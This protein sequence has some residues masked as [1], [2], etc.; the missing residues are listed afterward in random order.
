MHIITGKIIIKKTNMIEFLSMDVSIIETSILID[1][2]G[3]NNILHFLVIFI[4][5]FN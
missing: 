2:A 1:L 4:S 3:Q 5:S